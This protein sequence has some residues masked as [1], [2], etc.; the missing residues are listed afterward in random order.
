MTA[1]ADVLVAGAGIVGLSRAVALLSTFAASP[2]FSV[3][4]RRRA[5]QA[6]RSRPAPSSR[7]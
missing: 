6:H 7:E 5:V 1:K 4:P 2:Q 3:H